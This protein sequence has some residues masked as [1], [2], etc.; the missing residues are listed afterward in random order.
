[1]VA[2]IVSLFLVRPPFTRSLATTEELGPETARCRA[3][4][5]AEHERNAVHSVIP[6][7]SNVLNE[8]GLTQR[9]SHRLFHEVDPVILPETILHDLRYGIRAFSRTFRIR[10]CSLLI[11]PPGS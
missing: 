8:S 3:I 10:P 7:I 6:A 9:R 2:I 5:H 11:P 4:H 1:V